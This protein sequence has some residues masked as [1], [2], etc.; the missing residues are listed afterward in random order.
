MGWHETEK[1]LE[2]DDLEEGPYSPE[3]YL[4]NLTGF[5]WRRVQGERKN[6]N[7]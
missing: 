5:S 4:W 2:V 3:I 1:I 7:P 6:K